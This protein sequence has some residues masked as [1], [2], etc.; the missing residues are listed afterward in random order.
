MGIK[1]QGLLPTLSNIA[2]TV[3]KYIATFK[4]NKMEHILQFVAGAV[5][6]FSLCQL[7]HLIT[8]AI[9]KDDETV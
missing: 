4:L 5:I 2:I 3:N 7:Y 8:E 6:G 9:K 1:K